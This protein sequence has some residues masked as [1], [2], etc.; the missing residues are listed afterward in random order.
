MRMEAWRATP[1][2]GEASWYGR[3]LGVLGLVS[4]RFVCIR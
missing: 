4:V 2:G 1:E 3:S